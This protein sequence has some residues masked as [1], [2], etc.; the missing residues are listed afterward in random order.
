MIRVTLN[1]TLTYVTSPLFISFPS[2][3]RSTG[4]L[5]LNFLFFTRHSNQQQNNKCPSAYAPKQQ[6][7]ASTDFLVYGYL[8]QENKEHNN[9]LFNSKKKRV[10]GK[11]LLGVP[12]IQQWNYMEKNSLGYIGKLDA[13]ITRKCVYYGCCINAQAMDLFERIQKNRKPIRVSFLL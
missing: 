9:L 3:D 12:S 11:S 8:I 6:T 7:T 5:T 4:I 10:C 2:Y 1:D 13:F